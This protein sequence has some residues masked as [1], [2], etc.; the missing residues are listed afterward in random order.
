MVLYRDSGGTPGTRVAESN[1]V[2]TI[3]AGAAGGWVN[4]TAPATTLN[5]GDYWIVFHTGA[6]GG[7][8]RNRGGDGAANWYGNN[9]DVFADGPGSTFGTGTTGT[10]TLSVTATYTVGN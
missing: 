9:T 1:T 4:F 7:V 3:A 8:A 6:T 5:P 2:A 10:G